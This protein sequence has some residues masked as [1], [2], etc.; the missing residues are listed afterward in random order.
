MDD[1]FFKSCVYVRDSCCFQMC[2]WGHAAVH[3]VGPDQTHLVQAHLVQTH[4]AL[5]LRQAFS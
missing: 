4:L 2:W 3:A 5:E 1:C